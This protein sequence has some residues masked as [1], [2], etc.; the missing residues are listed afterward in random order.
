[1][2]DTDASF[3]SVFA[4][5]LQGEAIHVLGLGAPR[6]LPVEQWQVADEHDEELL[7]MCVGPVLDVG[8]GPGRLTAALAEAG[9]EAMGL[10][11]VDEAVALTLGRG[12][13]AVRGDVFA[14]VPR[15]REWATVLLAD[16]NLGIGG[17]PV[18]L[19][20][21]LGQVL[22][23]GG[24]VVAEV[25]PPGTAR[26]QVWAQLRAGEQTSRPFRWAVVGID[27]IADVA[28]EAGF[29]VCQH[30]LFGDRDVVALDRPESW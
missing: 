10:D 9:V 2:T 17:D 18:A 11:V 22:R 24:R 29:R 20:R 28:A 15:E 30:A 21:R 7:R 1:M 8:C 23:P 16:G 13:A 26:Q 27:D 12:A 4:R 19:L 5:A 6:A 14:P 25:A 3:S